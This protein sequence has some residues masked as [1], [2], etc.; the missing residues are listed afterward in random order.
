M[1]ANVSG[2]E[3]VPTAKFAGQ[4]DIPSMLTWATLTW[5]PSATIL[6]CRVLGAVLT[7]LN[8]LI[9]HPAVAPSCRVPG[10]DFSLDQVSSLPVRQAPDS[11]LAFQV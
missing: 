2:G 4:T 11:M 6:K 1:R 9:N 10:S 3:E 8:D 5:A 7:E